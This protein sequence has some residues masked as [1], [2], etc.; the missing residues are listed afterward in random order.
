MDGP[1]L[2]AYAI[3]ILLGCIIFM[4]GK[5]KVKENHGKS[6]ADEK[7]PRDR[8]ITFNVH[9]EYALPQEDIKPSEP[10][11]TEPQFHGLKANVVNVN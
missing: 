4:L 10:L 7:S 2:V 11:M 9:T 6:E 1:F 8:V 3:L 5:Q